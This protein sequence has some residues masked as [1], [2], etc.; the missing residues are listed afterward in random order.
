LRSNNNLASRK[1]EDPK[2]SR[3]LCLLWNDIP[4]PKIELVLL[5]DKTI[6]LQL[7][8][9]PWRQTRLVM[10]KDQKANGRMDA[11]PRATSFTKFS[12]YLIS[13]ICEKLIR[14]K[15]NEISLVICSYKKATE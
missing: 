5:P 2:A 12:R 6:T 13:E 14:I 11:H 15:K 1:K 10:G 7:A 9:P 4:H 8:Q 3:P